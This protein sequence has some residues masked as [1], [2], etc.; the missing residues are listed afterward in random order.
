MSQIKS[1]LVFQKFIFKQGFYSNT[2]AETFCGICKDG[3][4]RFTNSHVISSHQ[5]KSKGNHPT[6]W[7]KEKRTRLGR[8]VRCKEYVMSAD[9]QA[10]ME[11]RLGRQVAL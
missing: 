2:F 5:K 10:E 6:R 1:T 3:T 7:E 4:L 8:A 9:G 11:M